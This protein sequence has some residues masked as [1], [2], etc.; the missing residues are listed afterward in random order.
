MQKTTIG[1]ALLLVA[2]NARRHRDRDELPAPQAKLMGTVAHGVVVGKTGDVMTAGGPVRGD[3]TANGL[4]FRGIPYAAPPVGPLRWKPPAD[5]AAWTTVRDATA[6]GKACPQLDNTIGGKLAWDEDCL[7]LN[8][9]TPKLAGKAA[10]MVW[11]HGGG[12]VQGGSALPI[13][14][15][16]TLAHDGGVV[17]VSINYRLGPLGYL[18][19]PALTAE[20]TAHHASGNFGLLDQIAALRWVQRNIAAFGGD[21][22]NVTIFGES[23]GGESV[24]ALLASPLAAG[25]FAKG[26][27]ESAQC[28]GYGKALRALHDAKARVE[29][30]EAQGLRIASALGCIAPDAAACLRGKGADELIH[31]SPAALGFLGD[32]EHYGLTV[33]GY[34]LTDAPAA[35]LDAGKLANV[36]MIVGTT[37]DEATLF[38]SKLPMRGP[39]AYDVVVHKIFGT[40]A[41]KVLAQYPA[42]RGTVKQAFD[43]LVTDVVFACPTRRAAKALRARQPH[44]YR[45]E[46]AH[47]TAKAQAK[48]M[49]ASHGSEIPFVFGTVESPTDDERKL[50]KTMLGYWTRF[51]RT[52]DPNGGGA[53]AWTAYDAASDSYLELDTPIAAKQGLHRAGCDTLDG[54]ASPGVERGE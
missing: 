14:D 34:A 46:F 23:A 39:L 42:R 30:G 40:D 21:P 11:I 12:L 33:D 32:G 6:F 3:E 50:A 24:C 2:C 19:H 35:L 22:S 53:P 26:V 27:I 8:V 18:A 4:A 51:A 31:A 17:V 48:G 9:W 16:A 25:L 28:V 20:D 49:G 5:A 52:G 43:A 37:A 41:P 36:P 13:Y 54:I 47:V 7:T 29:S 44:V 38:T 15:G 1:L 10:V 45:Y